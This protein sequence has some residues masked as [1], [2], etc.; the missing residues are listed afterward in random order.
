MSGGLRVADVDVP[1]GSR[2][3]RAPVVSE[4]PMG[5]RATM[6]LAVVNGAAPGPRV[7][8]SAVHGDELDGVMI[9]QD[10]LAAVDASSLRGALIVAPI[11]NVPGARLRSRYL[12]DRRDLNR[13]FPGGD[14][15]SAAARLAR[16]VQE[17]VVAGAS[18]G[19]DL[20]SAARWRTNAPQVRVTPENPTARRLAEAFAAPF[21]V[22]ADL[23]P[24]SLR[25]LAHDAGAPTITDEAGGPL[26]FD[27]DAVAVGAAGVRRGR[28][29]WGHLGSDGPYTRSIPWTARPDHPRPPRPSVRDC[30]RWTR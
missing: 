25:G 10:V 8:V 16:L 23:R 24:G 7:V 30:W 3:D 17:H 1:A 18:A 11:V 12:P 19:F 26:R 15:G 29:R 2:R 9:R 6:P 20:H 21:A 4:S 5:E 14:A 27:T 13:S 28:R 22:T